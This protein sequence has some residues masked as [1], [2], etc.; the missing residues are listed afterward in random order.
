MK[1]RNIITIVI[2]VFFLISIYGKR[3]NAQEQLNHQITCSFTISGFPLIG[4][5]YSYFFDQYNAAQAT[6][7]VI[8]GKDGVLFAASAGYSYYFGNKLWHPNIGLEF[9]LMRGPPD[10]EEKNLYAIH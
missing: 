1:T 8:P 6:F 3:S 9:L 5:G 4:V 2:I 7:F 10:P